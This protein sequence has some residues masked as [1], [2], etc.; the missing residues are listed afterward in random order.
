MEHQKISIIWSMSY[1]KQGSVLSLTGS[2]HIFQ[3]MSMDWQCL[4]EHIFMIMRIQGKEAS[5][6]GELYYLTM[7]NQ[8]YRASWSQVRCSLQMFII[9]MEFVLMLY[10]QCYILTLGNRKEN[11]CRMKMEPISTMKQLISFAI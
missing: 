5:L 8:K 11:M 4:M 3:E 2:Q 9:S 7:G 10:L 1:I 6:T